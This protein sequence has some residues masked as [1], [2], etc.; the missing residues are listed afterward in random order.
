MKRLRSP[1]LLLSTLLFEPAAK[2]IEPHILRLQVRFD[3]GDRVGWQVR[4]REF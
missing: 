3:K 1:A 4:C 2:V